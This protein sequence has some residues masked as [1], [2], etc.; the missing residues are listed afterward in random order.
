MDMLVLFK[1]RHKQKPFVAVAAFIETT[2]ININLASFRSFLETC[3]DKNTNVRS[4]KY[5]LQ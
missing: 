4:G 2:F 3:K 1:T 5:L